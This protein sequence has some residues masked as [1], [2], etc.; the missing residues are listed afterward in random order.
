[1]KEL[2]RRRRRRRQKKKKKKKGKCQRGE[3]ERESPMSTLWQNFLQ[4]CGG[5][6]G[7][8]NQQSCWP[9]NFSTVVVQARDVLGWKLE[10]FFPFIGWGDC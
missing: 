5:L 4:L 8:M 10:F 6:G 7:A 3:R 9:F 2:K 1:M